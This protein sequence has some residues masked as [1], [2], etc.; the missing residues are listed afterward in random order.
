MYC[1]N[2]GGDIPL[3]VRF[4]NHCGA[5]ALPPGDPE[6]TRVAGQDAAAA[7]DPEATRFAARSPF[8]ERQ[9]PPARVEQLA[10]HEERRPAQFGGEAPRREVAAR[11]E[12][13]GRG[14]DEEA[15]R[16]IFTVRPT[17][18]FIGV[19]YALAALGAVGLIV[20]LAIFTAFPALYS[21]LAALPLLLIPA[22]RHLKRN[23]VR[24]TL[25]DSKIEIDQGFVSRRT[26]NIP[27]RNIQDVTVSATIPQRL[28]GFGDLLI[29]NANE[30][31]GTTNMH[32]IPDPRRHADLLLRELRR[33][34]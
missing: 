24:Y 6:A 33:W 15:E 31:G 11:P 19:G 18:L 4:C 9:S 23:S 13:D 7:R 12:A 28:L 30:M 22:Y 20:L 5:P 25:T 21:L 34:N 29:E 1:S 17:F 26:R 27:L 16:V 3:G 14:H 10:R 32:N 8:D 2:C